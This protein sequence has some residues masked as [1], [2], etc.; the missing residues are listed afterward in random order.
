[1]IPPDGAVQMVTL[2]ADPSRAGSFAGQFAVLQEGAYRL[3]LP[4]RKA[5]TNALIRRIQ[6]KLPELERENPQRN[7]ALLSRIAAQTDGTYFKGMPALLGTDAAEAAGRTPQGPHQCPSAVTVAPDPLWE[8]NWLRWLM[9]GFAACCVGMVDPAIVQT[10]I[11]T[12]PT[13]TQR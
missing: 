13:G 4:C 12:I 5:S 11:A 2:T 10:G 1:M 8:Q 7:D 9:I 3:E 6:V